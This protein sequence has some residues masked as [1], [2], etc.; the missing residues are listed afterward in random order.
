[1]VVII[2]V[3]LFISRCT[4][5]AASTW[6]C[7]LF[8][9]SIPSIRGRP[10]VGWMYLMT[11][12]SFFQ[13][14]L[15]GYFTLVQ[16]KATPN[17]RSGLDLFSRYSIFAVTWWK[18]CPTDSNYMGCLWWLLKYDPH[19]M[20]LIP[21]YSC[22]QV[23]LQS[24]QRYIHTWLTLPYPYCRSQWSFLV[25]HGPF[26]GWISIETLCHKLS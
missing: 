12:F 23:Y 26:H 14:S 17:S 3:W 11:R 5:N 15:S 8:V 20:F 10:M 25:I 1:M 24:C 13:S 7:R 9:P 16:R 19:I 18:C 2:P 21:L 4:P 6:Q 22:I